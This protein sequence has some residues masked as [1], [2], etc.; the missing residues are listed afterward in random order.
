MTKL[1][2]WNDDNQLVIETV[3]RWYGDYPGVLLQI[4]ELKYE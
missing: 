4:K 3:E 2:Y 1:N